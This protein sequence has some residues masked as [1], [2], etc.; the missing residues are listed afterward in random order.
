MATNTN[1]TTVQQQ[2]DPWLRP[3]YQGLLDAAEGW[4]RQPYQP[5]GGQRL[6][7]F[8]P[9]EVASQQ[10]IAALGQQGLPSQFMWGSQ[11]GQAAL[12]QMAGA[13]SR[14]YG[15]LSGIA[16]AYGANTQMWPDAN[17]PAYMNPYQ[18]NVT[19]IAAREAQKMGQRQ[20]QD[21]GSNAALSGAF[22]G[23]RHALLEGNIMQ[24]TRQ[25]I[26]DITQQG[27]RDAYQSAMGQF[28]ADRD[29]MLRGLGGQA[30]ALGM[31]NDLYQRGGQG[32]MGGAMNMANM[33]MVGQGM[34]L[35]L[36]NAMN[37]YG[38]QQRNLQ[39]AGLDIGYQDYLRQ[40]GMPEQRMGFLSGI[41]GGFPTTGTTSYYSYQPSASLLNSLLG[42]G[43][44]AAAMN[45]NT[46]PTG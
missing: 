12:G 44:G 19:D 10:G 20:L 17:I 15:D 16:Q 31:A 34:N 5:Y 3:S 13:G 32:L 25:Q 6:A 22:G 23:S 35:D 9:L 21:I 4:M 28:N 40:Q 38:T 43:I 41:L 18:Q 2:I 37:Q 14:G 27:Q 1:T 29:A 33:G 36:I 7:G 24:G 11:A 46:Q 8:S 26:A 42:V 45:R 39:Q 30:S